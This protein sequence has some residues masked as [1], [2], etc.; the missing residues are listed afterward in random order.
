PLP[1]HHTLLY[2]LIPIIARGLP[3]GPIPLSIPYSHIIPISQPQAFPLLLPSIMLPTFSP[4]ILPPFLNPIP[5]KKPES[6]PNP[7]VHPSEQHSPALDQSQ[8]AQ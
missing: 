7:E 1:F 4:I 6:T 5:N 3:Q 8:S 2:I